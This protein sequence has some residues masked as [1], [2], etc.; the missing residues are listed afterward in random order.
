MYIDRRTFFVTFNPE[1]F[2][3]RH[4][5]YEQLL[6]HDKPVS[7]IPMPWK[8][9]ASILEL[10]DDLVNEERQNSLTEIMASWVPFDEIGEPPSYIN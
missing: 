4:S 1:T 10:I 3:K 9:A 2:D 6:L 7:F 8:S 5:E